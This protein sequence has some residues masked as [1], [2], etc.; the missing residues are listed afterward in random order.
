MNVG[1]RPPFWNRSKGKTGP[2]LTY[3]MAA[4]CTGFVVR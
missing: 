3:K 4:G 1:V 2:S